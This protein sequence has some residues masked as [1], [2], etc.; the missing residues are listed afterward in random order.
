VNWI[1]RNSTRIVIAGIV[2]SFLIG[3]AIAIHAG[4]NLRYAD[5]RDYRQL[6]TNLAEKH[7]YTLDGI[8]KTAYRAPGFS[9]FLALP[10]A[11]GM[12]NTG[13]RLVNLSMFLLSEVLLALLARKLLSRFA[14][15][16]S[17][18]LALAYPVL[19]YTATILVPQTIGATL[20]LLGIWLL[21]RSEKPST[22]SVV[23][24]GIVW[25]I[26][27]LTIPTFLFTLGCLVIWMLWK[28]RNFR[29]MAFSFAAPLIFVVGSWSA[30]NYVVFHTF[31]F[32][33]TNSGMNLMQG[34]SENSMTMSGSSTNVDKYVAAAWGMSEIDKDRYYRASA[35]KWIKE[36][37]GAALRLYV[38]KVAEYFT[39]TEKTATNNFATQA[40]QPFWRS[41]IMLFTYEPLLLL[42]IARVAVARR[43][44]L[45]NVELFFVCLYFLNAPYAAI[46]YTRIRYRL[47]M[48]WI[49][50]LIDAG[51]IQ[52]IFIRLCSRRSIEGREV[53]AI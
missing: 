8:D 14:A 3:A 40:E 22:W 41:L 19:L 39:F 4:S 36:H 30:R 47:P 45:S 25:G 42:L 35:M 31:F 10:V 52:I 29:R 12:G 17:V 21:I 50:L 32:V 27:L 46:F 13:L 53:R 49:M 9:C 18:L 33:A 1:G 51:M 34:N 15:A 26:L 43:Y 7:T 44:P 16:V 37:P 38:L 20:L 23:L 5:E 24:A 28:R 6:A 48:D 2:I 11:F